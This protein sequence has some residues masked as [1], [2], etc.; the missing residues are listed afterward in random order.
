MSPKL[1][2]KHE[3]G[4]DLAEY[5]L[6]LALIALLVLGSVSLI[7]VELESVFTAIAR[8]LVF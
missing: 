8:V 2:R 5:A 7:G 1:Q 4:Q 6:L 3:R